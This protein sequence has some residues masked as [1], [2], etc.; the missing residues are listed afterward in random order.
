M[1][2]QQE[3]EYKQKVVAANITKIGSNLDND[4]D[5]DK[6]SDKEIDQNRTIQKPNTKQT[7]NRIND[8]DQ[9]QR[10]KA[11]TSKTI[12]IIIIIAMIK[13]KTIYHLQTV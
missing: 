4:K 5:K 11:H 1:H 13:K 7:N 9:I 8:H 2:Q 3:Q 12:M 10:T 6:N